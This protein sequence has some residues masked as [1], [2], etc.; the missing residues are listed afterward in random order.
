MKKLSQRGFS[1]VETVLVLVIIAIVAFTLWYVF[2]AKSNTSN[3]YD[4]TAGN[5]NQ[6]IK[7]TQSG[8]VVQTKTD[9]KVGQYLADGSG[10]PLYTYNLDTDNTSNCTGSCLSTWPVYEATSTTNL[11]DKVGT[12]TR[13]DGTKQYTYNKKPLY[14]FTSDS[15]GKITGNGLEGFS[16]ATP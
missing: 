10:K 6:I 1:A 9:S 15:V 8:P 11:P 2:N 4:S 16:V 14:Y 13:T 12:I 3:S 7:K 5:Q